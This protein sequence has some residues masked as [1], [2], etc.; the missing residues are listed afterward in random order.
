MQGKPCRYKEE[1]AVR[2]YDESPVAMTFPLLLIAAYLFGGVPFG[3]LVARAKG[4]DIMKAGSGNIG[5]TN[6]GRVLGKGPGIAVWVLD[7]T[8]SLLPT[9]AARFL[10]SHGMGPLAPET[11]WFLVGFA[12]IVGH[13]ASPFLGFKGG[14]GI[15]T[16]LGAIVGTAPLVALCCFVLFAV[17]LATTRYM[18]I[19]SVVGVSSVVLFAYGFGVTSQLL[20]VFVLVALFVAYRHRTNFRRLREGT[21][22][23][24][25]LQK[26]GAPEEGGGAAVERPIQ[27]RLR[28]KGTSQLPDP[29]EVDPTWGPSSSVQIV[30]VVVAQLLEAGNRLTAVYDVDMLKISIDDKP[31]GQL[32]LDLAPAVLR[33]LALIADMNPIDGLARREGRVAGTF[34]EKPFELEAESFPVT[35]GTAF[36]LTRT[37]PL[38]TLSLFSSS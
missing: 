24:F 25:S 11:I 33:R 6:V 19:A 4:V 5:A 18:A 38:Q 1:A 28:L 36:V 20:P 35:Q 14:K 3:V 32:P 8:K 27:E 21:E 10:L 23:R 29:Y 37:T 26:A 16:A 30:E 34:D 22:P 31:N 17:V 15:S 12:A 9:V 7:V 2:R 13:C